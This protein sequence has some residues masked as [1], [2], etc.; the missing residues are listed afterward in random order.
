MTFSLQNA[1]WWGGR[2]HI[3][4][5]I[6]VFVALAS[7]DNAAIAVIPG[8]INPLEE[9]LQTSDLALG[10]LT[11]WTILV[12]A[13]SS[14]PWGYLGDRSARKALLFW[15]TVIWVA[16]SLLSATASSYGALFAW[17]MITALGLGAVASVGFSVISDLVA[18]ARR[19]LALSVWGLSQGL[20]R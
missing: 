8:M 18:P 6:V 19:G 5:T 7:L 14:V 1:R 16:G 13:L 20:E 10:I 2:R 17:Q 12:A 15:G 9:S 11:G 4:F 3:V